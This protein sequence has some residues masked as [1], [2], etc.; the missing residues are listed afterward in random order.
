MRSEVAA[1]LSALRNL[2]ISLGGTPPR[3]EGGEEKEK[4]GD[5]G[6]R[7]RLEDLEQ[8]VLVSARRVEV[9]LVVLFGMRRCT[10]LEALS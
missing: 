7:E 6:G 8:A 2:V 3:R 1:E 10:S 4:E 5:G 9:R